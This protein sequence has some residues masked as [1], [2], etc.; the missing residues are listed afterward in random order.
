[1]KTQQQKI[2]EITEAIKNADIENIEYSFA[3]CGGIGNDYYEKT[4][5]K[6]C[7]QI[8]VP[9]EKCLDDNSDDVEDADYIEV[10]QEIGEAISKLRIFGEFEIDQDGE[11]FTVWSLES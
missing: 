10:A 7:I 9:F 11:T 4:E 1:M 5:Y 8:S 3:R 2:E 6:D